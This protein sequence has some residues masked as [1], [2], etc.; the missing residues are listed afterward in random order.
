MKDSVIY[1]SLKEDIERKVK[2]ESRMRWISLVVGILEH[3]FGKLNP[4]WEKSIES[5]SIPQ[6]QELFVAL[7][8]F[9]NEE[10]LVNWLSN[11]K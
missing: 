7:Y 6:L 11:L 1:Q 8:G 10:D 5:L 9:K 2:E 4:D 3:I